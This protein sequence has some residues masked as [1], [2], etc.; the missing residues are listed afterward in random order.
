MCTNGHNFFTSSSLLH[1][2]VYSRLLDVQHTA[3]C[4]SRQSAHH[5]GSCGGNV[6]LVLFLAEAAADYRRFIDNRCC[7]DVGTGVC[8]RSAWLLQQYESTASV[9]NSYDVCRVS[10][11]RQHGSSLILGNT[12]TSRQCWATFIGGQCDKREFSRSPLWCTDVFEWTGTFLSGSRLHRNFCDTRSKTIAICDLRAAV[13]SKNQKSDIWTKV[14][15]GLWVHQSGMIFPLGWKIHL[16]A[17]FKMISRLIS[18]IA[19][20]ML[21]W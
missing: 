13:H 3:R 5:A 18:K 2:S 17:Y 7:Q 11:T 9:V 15:Q 6:Q 8:R 14:I 1:G 20:D 10:R 12:I 19:Q 21:V 4:S 16:W